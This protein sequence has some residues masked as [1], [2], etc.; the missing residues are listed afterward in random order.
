[1]K[2]LLSRFGI[3]ARETVIIAVLVFCLTGGLIIKYS[4]WNKPDDFDYS[5][6]DKQFEE[7]TKQDFDLLKNQSL[8]ELQKER[9][10]E[11]KKTADSL[12]SGIEN[13]SKNK[14][15]KINRIIN[16]NNA[17]SADLMLLP[18]I[19]EVIAERIIEYREKTGGFKKIEEI[20]NVKG[21]G[22][23]KFEMIKAFITV[24]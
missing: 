19:G 13:Q 18:G 10:I 12:Y 3:T 1:M 14:V 20:K 21:I 6:P 9:S 11:I 7:K 2:E 23:K 5:G 22:D 17:Y 8:N 15:I 4:G 16:L 24:E